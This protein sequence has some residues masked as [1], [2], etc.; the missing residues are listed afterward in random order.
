M[1]EGYPKFGWQHHTGAPRCSLN[2][3]DWPRGGTASS[4]SDGVIAV[5][6]LAVAASVLPL[7]PPSLAVL[8]R[9]L[10]LFQQH[11]SGGLYCF[12]G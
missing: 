11:L 3:C 5:S 7:L 2:D 12:S 6:V 9:S 4:I 8:L 1:Q 10:F